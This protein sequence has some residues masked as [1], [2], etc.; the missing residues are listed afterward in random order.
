MDDD[1]SDLRKPLLEVGSA[2]AGGRLRTGLLVTGGV[3]LFGACAAGPAP[4]T[5]PPSSQTHPSGP[6]DPA[7]AQRGRVTLRHGIPATLHVKPVARV[8]T[9][10]ILN[11]STGPDGGGNAHPGRIIVTNGGT[12]ATSDWIASGQA[13]FDDAFSVDLARDVMVLFTSEPPRG[14][15]EIDYEFE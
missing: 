8:A 4:E 3:L 6:A 13:N 9:P 14:W 5:H 15:I 12:H 1:M 2:P 7:A 11:V 10:R